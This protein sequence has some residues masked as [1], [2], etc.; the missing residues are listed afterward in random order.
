MQFRSNFRLLTPGEGSSRVEGISVDCLE[1][2]LSQVLQDQAGSAE[3]VIQFCCNCKE[4]AVIVK[5]SLTII[6]FL[7]TRPS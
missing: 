1:K 5:R 4:V 7:F 6:S 2:R 3:D